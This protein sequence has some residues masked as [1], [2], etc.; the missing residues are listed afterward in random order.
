MATASFW[1]FWISSL[2]KS[3]S[4]REETRRNDVEGVE[5]LPWIAR[6][7]SRHIGRW[8]LIR[9]GEVGTPNRQSGLRSLLDYNRD[10]Q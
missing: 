8:I 1:V 2:T 4:M 9:H 3:I 6:L 10:P 7:P 5:V